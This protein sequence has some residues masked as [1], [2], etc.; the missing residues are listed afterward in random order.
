MVKWNMIEFSDAYALR[1]MF[2]KKEKKKRKKEEVRPI[3]NV[4]WKS[5]YL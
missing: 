5:L 4:E 2:L 1:P 3:V